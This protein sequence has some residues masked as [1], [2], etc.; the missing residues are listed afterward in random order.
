MHQ[1]LRSLGDQIA[2]CEQRVREM[3]PGPIEF[4]HIQSRGSGELLDR[5]ELLRAEQAVASRE[6][7]LVVVED[8]GRICRR[9]RAIDFCEQCEDAETRFLALNDTIDTASDGWR[10]S[11]FFAS[12]KHESSNA[13]TSKRIRRTLRQRFREGGVVQTLVYGYIK[14][15]GATSDAEVTKDPA[16]EPVWDEVFRRLEDGASFG[17]VSDWLNATGVPPGKW[18]RSRQWN[19]QLLAQAVR[20]PILKGVRVRNGKMSRRVNKTGRR[21]TVPAPESERL[22]RVCPHLAFVAPER[23]DRVIALLARR[24]AGYSREHDGRADKR[25][26]VPRKRTTWPGQHAVCGVCGRF[27]YWGKYAGGRKV[28]LCSGAVDYRC[29]NGVSFDG[30]EAARRI[31]SAVLGMVE[32]LPEFDAEFAAKVREQIATGTAA[33]DTERARLDRELD[34]LVHQIENVTAAIAAVGQSPGLLEKLRTLETRKGDVAADRAVLCGRPVPVPDLPPVAELKARAR[35]AVGGM[36]FDDPE[37]SRVLNRLIPRLELLPYRLLGGGSLVLRA[38]VTVDLASLL[39][40]G[41]EG[42]VR[43]ELFVDLFD[44]PQRAAFRERVVALRASGATE[45]DAARQLGLTLT[46]AQRAMDLHRQMAAAGISD[47]YVLETISESIMYQGR[48]LREIAERVYDGGQRIDPSDDL[49]G[50][51]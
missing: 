21:K 25:A 8:L 23:Y 28:M 49:G 24:N 31:V 26:G 46:A 13:D 42:V 38:R 34:T 30:P 17:E 10:M 51:R 29:W 50:I 7:D 9:N 4:T 1:D 37:L 12:F 2:L 41:L 43:R 35:A 39:P 11:A 19:P 47:P 45:R 14:P 33:R 36:D 22:E 48:R 32:A 18:V 3:Y 15:P 5:E 40:G 6:Y 44:P 27:V 20:N 16:A